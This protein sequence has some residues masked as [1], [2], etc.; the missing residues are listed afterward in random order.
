MVRPVRVV[1][2]KP[3]AETERA[4]V[5][6]E[7]MASKIVP[8]ESPQMEN[9]EYGV[10]VPMVTKPDAFW[11]KIS[12]VFREKLPVARRL[13]E[14]PSKAI[15]VSA[16]DTSPLESRVPVTVRVFPTSNSSEALERRKS[17]PW[18]VSRVPV[19]SP[20]AFRVRTPAEFWRPAPVKSLKNSLFRSR[21]FEICISATSSSGKEDVAVVLKTLMALAAVMVN[22]A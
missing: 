2:A 19:Q 22:D 11:A 15:E 12:S 20:V 7:V 10:A 8:T 14:A 1:V 6:A 17:E 13:V 16:I 18:K 9:L 5:E 4:E 3:V 21:L